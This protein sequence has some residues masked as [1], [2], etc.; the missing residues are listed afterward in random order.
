MEKE[1]NKKERKLSNRNENLKYR[2]EELSKELSSE[3]WKNMEE[4]VA[5]TQRKYNRATEEIKELAEIACKH[6]PGC[7]WLK[8]HD[9]NTSIK[10]E[11]RWSAICD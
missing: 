8:L 4:S 2:I 1:Q 5:Q 11:D 6:K 7:K 10:L 9:R 3:N